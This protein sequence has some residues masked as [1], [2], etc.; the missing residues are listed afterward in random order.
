MLRFHE[1]RS[2]CYL[3]FASSNAAKRAKETKRAKCF[4]KG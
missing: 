1:K 2:V 3:G 4:K